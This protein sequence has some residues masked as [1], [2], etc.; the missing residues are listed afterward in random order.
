MEPK[1][2]ESSSKS[3]SLDKAFEVEGPSRGKPSSFKLAEKE[4]RDRRF[5]LM[6]AERSGKIDSRITEVSKIAGVKSRIIHVAWKKYK[7]AAKK[8]LSMMKKST[9][10]LRDAQFLEAACIALDGN[11]SSRTRVLLQRLS[12]YPNSGIRR[13]AEA[14]LDRFEPARAI[15]A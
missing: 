6:V 3:I 2:P 5:A 11:D 8:A 15:P 13:M 9:K 14:L 10:G 12:S 1:R 4:D 7:R